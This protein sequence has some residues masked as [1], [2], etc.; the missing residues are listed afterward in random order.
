M[1]LASKKGC[2][3]NFTAD[4]A[5]AFTDEAGHGTHVIGTIAGTGSANSRYRGVAT[6][7]GESGGTIRA[8][9]VWGSDNTGNGSWM[10]SAIDWMALPGE[11]DNQPAPLLINISGG[12]LGTGL[13]GTDSRSRKLDYQVW[14]NRQL[15]VVAARNEGP[16]SQTIRTPG[17]AKN[18]LTVGSVFDNNGYLTAGDIAPG[19]SRG[20]TGDGRMKPNLVAPGQYVTSAQA[21]TIGTY[22]SNYGTSMAT[23]HV[24]GLAATLMEHYPSFQFNPAM[25]RAHMMATA[26]AHEGVLGKSNDYGLG[27]PSGYVA[28][29]AHT[30]NDG[31][32]TYRYWGNV[33]AQGYQYGDITVPPDTQRLVVVL[34][35]DEPPASAGA[36]RV[37]RRQQSATRHIPIESRALPR[38]RHRARLWPGC[39]DH[40]RRSDSTREGLH[41]GSGE[42]RRRLHVRRDAERLDPVVR[43]VGD[44]G[45]ALRK[46]A[47]RDVGLRRDDAPGWRDDALL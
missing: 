37:R 43:G 28:H 35:W 25:L 47:W 40:P 9:K 29:W 11:C 17:V 4:A 15:Y 21:G 38:P 30:N 24:T 34:T 27:R 19:S 1:D 31:W 8:A 32:L 46:P 42:S 14:I 3:F 20:P 33:S 12:G 7:V 23:P 13:T 6:G 41:D 36:S 5:G 16:A 22:I 2:G 18:A 26:M 45:R 10:E 39:H 44:R